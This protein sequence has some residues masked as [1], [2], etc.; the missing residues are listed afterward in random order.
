MSVYVIADLHL[1]TNEQTNKSMEKFGSRWQNY[2]EKINKNWRA[3]ITD[4]DTV[5]I[6]GDISWALRLEEARE[7]LAFLDSLPGKK[8][9]GKGNHDFWWTTAAKTE[10]FFAENGMTSMSLLYN[11]AY[12]VEDFVVCGTR[13]WYYDRLGDKIPPETD[14]AKMTAREAARLQLSI[15]AADRLLIENPDKERLVFLHFP[16]IWNGQIFP[17]IVEVLQRNG[18]G[19]VFFGH[20]HGSYSLPTSFVQ[21]GISYALISADFLNFAPRPIFPASFYG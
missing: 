16:P 3:V 11:N 10:R 5:V 9:I 8:L 2:T 17:E 1:S 19:R 18:I 21:D 12:I 6:P 20:I 15:D 4:D 14:Y 13:G 7:D